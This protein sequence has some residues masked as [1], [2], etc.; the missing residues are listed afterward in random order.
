[1]KTG[2]F[3]GVASKTHRA[4]ASWQLLFRILAIPVPENH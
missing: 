2:D 3:F 4:E 1:M